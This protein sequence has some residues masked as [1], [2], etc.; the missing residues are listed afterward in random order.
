MDGFPS[1]VPSRRRSLWRTGLL[2]GIALSMLC[3]GIGCGDFTLF[4]DEESN[5]SPTAVASPDNAT[6][7]ACQKET[8]TL[9][10][11][12]SSDPD[13]DALTYL[14]EFSERPE[15]SAA[16]LQAETASQ[17]S[18]QPDEAGAYTIDLTVED[19]GGRSDTANVTVTASSDPVAD[20]GEA[21][22]GLVGDEVTLDGGGSVNPE[23]E[24]G[25]GGLSFSWSLIDP[26][27][28]ESDLGTGDEATFPAD[29]EGT[30]TATLEV[31][32]DSVTDSDQVD[33][34]VEG[35]ESELEALQSG[36]Y[37]FTVVETID[38]VFFAAALETVLYPGRTLDETVDVPSL[39]EVPDTQTITLDLGDGASVALEAEIKQ[40]D[41]ADE[42]YTLTGTASGT[43]SLPPFISCQLTRADCSGRLTPDTTNTVT[44]FITISNPEVTGSQACSDATNTEGT[45]E[46]TLSGE[47]Q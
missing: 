14:W 37:E 28:I 17:A 15:G 35:G 29:K 26:D 2:F 42:F 11:T 4:G 45:I 46:L 10:G 27:D 13:E 41:E 9:D 21:Q 5:Q 3:V 19:E 40:E 6:P 38:G 44:V 23:E 1:I 43:V 8:V 7:L 34:E 20:A 36:P 47:L 32:R 24:C 31:T 22:Q 18:F 25:P 30:Y 12:G 16:T 33:I 39:D